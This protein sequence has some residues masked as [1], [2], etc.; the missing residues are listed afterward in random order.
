MN[1]DDNEYIENK[2]GKLKL[3]YI[4]TFLVMGVLIMMVVFAMMIVNF[5]L[6]DTGKNEY[7]V[8]EVNQEN[9]EQI[10]SLLEK[11]NKPYCESIYKIEY[12][13]LFPNDKIAKVYCRNGKKIS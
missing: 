2:K 13:Q 10:I 1:L 5:I 9:K 11:E 7:Y 8:L 4:I 12:E 6:S 3:F